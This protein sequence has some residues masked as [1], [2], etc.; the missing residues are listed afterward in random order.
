MV[1]P[2]DSLGPTFPSLK[3]YD[4]RKSDSTLLPPCERTGPEKEASYLLTLVSC[5]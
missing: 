5:L 1:T 3:L 4:K 2:T